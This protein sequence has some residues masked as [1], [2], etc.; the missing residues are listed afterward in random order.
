MLIL[1]DN[2]K[3]QSLGITQSALASSIENS[4]IKLGNLLIRDG[5]YQYNIRFSSTLQNKNDIENIYFKV[6]N[7]LFQL[8]DVATVL[9]HPQKQ[10]GMVLQNG[11]DAV[12]FAVIKQ[13]DARMSD[14]K[15]KLNELIAQ[16][17][18]DYPDIQFD[19]TRNQTSLS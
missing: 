8:K 2:P 10:K 7:R 16:F 13:S 5:Q 3:L 11:K 12:T 18:K 17:E 19:I 6:N 1:P 4:N 14:L 9:E 15:N